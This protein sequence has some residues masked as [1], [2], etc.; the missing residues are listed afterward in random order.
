L[1]IESYGLKS[2]GLYLRLLD[3]EP[4]P[5]FWKP[6]QLQSL[7]T[8]KQDL[9]TA[10]VLVLPSLEKPFHLFVTVDRNLDTGSWRT[11][12]ASGLSL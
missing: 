1:W 6:E 9:I 5:L 8:L 2:K 11:E 10:P 7:D 12:A 3:G 4:N